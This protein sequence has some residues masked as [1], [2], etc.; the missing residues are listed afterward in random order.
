MILYRIKDKWFLISNASTAQD[1]I[2]AQ[3][4]ECCVHVDMI[5]FQTDTRAFFFDFFYQT[6]RKKRYRRKLKMNVNH[7]KFSKEILKAKFKSIH[8]KV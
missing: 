4:L 6:E 1:N 5:V 7:D 3:F 8:E 2:V